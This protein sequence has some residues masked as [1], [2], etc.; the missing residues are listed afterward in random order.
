MSVDLREPFTPQ[1]PTFALHMMA[2]GRLCVVSAYVDRLL[3]DLIQVFLG[4]T[5]AQAAVIATQTERIAARCNMIKHLAAAD[6]PSTEWREAIVRVV[7]RL[8]TQGEQRNRFVHDQWS[9]TS[10]S[11]ERLDRRTSVKKRQAREAPQLEFDTK[12]ITPVGEVDQLA[13]EYALTA[14]CLLGA[15]K[16]LEFWR[17]EGRLPERSMLL[18]TDLA[19]LPPRA[20]NPPRA[21]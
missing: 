5:D 16:D 3:T 11:L 7:N 4:C 21:Q 8:Q 1:S 17:H 9:L 10:G 19:R 15:T 14:I 13:A 6:P 20:P 2:L 12:H 18:V